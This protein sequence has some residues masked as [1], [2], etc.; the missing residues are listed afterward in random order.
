MK[1]HLLF[2]ITCAFCFTQNIFGQNGTCIP[3]VG[4]DCVTAPKYIDSVFTTNALT[5]FSN[6]GTN[7]NTQDQNYA[8]YPSKIARETA[9]GNFTVHIGVNV[10]SVVYIGVWI[11][12]NNDLVF[13]SGEQVYLSSGIP[14]SVDV[15]V[16]VPTTAALDTLVFRV[17]TG[18]TLTGACDSTDAGETED[19]RLLVLPDVS[20]IIQPLA[21]DAWSIYPNPAGDLLHVDF[22]ANSGEVEISVIDLLGN[23]VVSENA[24]GEKC[25]M[26]LSALPHGMYFVRVNSNGK[27]AMKKFVR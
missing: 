11:D 3:S 1:K 14:T 23:V 26:D 19:Y 5:N 6:L 16:N 27:T 24:A 2:A 20:G 18:T 8:D 4:L 13:G 10:V 7:C 25:E 12:W 21:D 15:V 17:R 22:A 9:G